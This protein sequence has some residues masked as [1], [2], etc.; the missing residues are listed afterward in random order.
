MEALVAEKKELKRLEDL[1]GGE[2]ELKHQRE[3]IDRLS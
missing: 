3:K 1:E 2:K